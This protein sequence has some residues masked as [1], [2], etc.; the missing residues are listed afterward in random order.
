ME[1]VENL[2]YNYL[3]D[4][5]LKENLYGITLGSTYNDIISSC[6]TPIE[7]KSFSSEGGLSSTLSY[8]GFIFH[9]VN[10]KVIAI[11]ISKANTEILKGIKI[12]DSVNNIYSTF[13]KIDFFYYPDDNTYRFFR[14]CN[15]GFKINIYVT[16][17][18]IE[19]ISIN[20]M[21]P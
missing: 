20:N 6:G 14:K 18:I 3:D 12:T 1:T 8:D 5:Y 4:Y 15:G 17:G 10:N 9:L 7:E 19:S 11:D 2:T 16:T 21:Y 13:S